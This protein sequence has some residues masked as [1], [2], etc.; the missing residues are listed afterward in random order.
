MGLLAA[1]A[2]SLISGV[3]SFFGGR[4]KNRADDARL[5]RQMDFQERM[6]GSAYQRSME[7]M[8]K[9]G[10][11][12]ILAYKQG[13]ASTP[14][15]AS[16][17]S[18]D[19]ITPAIN[20]ALSVRLATAQLKNIRANTIKT[21]YEADTGKSTAFLAD[22]DAQRGANLKFNPNNM[23]FMG[24]VAKGWSAFQQWWK[25]FSSKS[26]NPSNTGEGYSPLRVPIF[27]GDPRKRKK[28]K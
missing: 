1:L 16:M 26:S 4:A 10:L 20:S 27:P 11:N 5:Q 22:L 3:A 17:P 15:G 12:P 25:S 7:D 13:G 23:G 19:V 18:Q 24:N 6:S 28:S 21:L 9:A 2:P 8:K 14:S